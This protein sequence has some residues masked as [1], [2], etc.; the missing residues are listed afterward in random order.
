[1]PRRS[2][3]TLA[4]LCLTSYLLAAQSL[5][6]QTFPSQGAIVG[7]S[8][9]LPLQ[10]MGGAQPYM[11]EVA[12]GDLPPGCRLHAHGGYISWVPATAGDYH[13]TLSVTD[14]SIPQQ[15]AQREFTVHVIAG[16][17]LEWQPAPSVQGTMISGS[18]VVSNQTPL[19]F[20]LTVVIVAVNDI[21]RA[22]TLGY[23]NFR[24]PAQATTQVIPFG[25]SPG[26]GTYYVRADA[27]AHRAGHQHI[28]RAS[29]QTPA[30]LTV[31]QF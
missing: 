14:S 30:S 26:P 21:G 10:V 24:L 12:G 28:F 4:F 31:T 5:Q 3:L 25:A 11:W 23:Q 7:E 1:M 15:Q 9:L 13:F 17:T 22:T 2:L 19:E 29:K 16:L 20:S 8:F 18:A 6:I 27:V